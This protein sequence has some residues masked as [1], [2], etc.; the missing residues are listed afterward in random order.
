METLLQDVRYAI[1]TLVKVPGFTVVI[2]ISIALGIAANATVFSVANGL[3]WGVLP[4]KDPGRMVVFS[5]GKSISYPDY[6]DYRDQTTDVFEGG[7]TA[8]FPL[9][10]ASLGG[11]GEPERVW[12]Q[13]VSGNYFSVLRV[14]MA[15]GRPML[16]EEDR[17]IG[18]D[19]VVVLSH[20]LWQR[21]GA[22]WAALHRGGGCAGRV[23]RR[24]PRH[25]LRLLGTA[26]LGG[27]GHV[28]PGD[29]RR[30]DQ[31]GQSVADAQC[32]AQAGS[33]SCPR[34]GG[35]ERRQETH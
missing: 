28:R 6:M 23:P 10:P 19:Q 24:R 32:A 31:A 21:R 9:I 4:V 35:R 18:R 15:L 17:V 14:N 12:G 30:E 7:V 2:I 1:R 20:N 26:R 29:G 25:R 27:T 11:T 5:E 22:E 8:H 34:G 3:L 33:Q 13:A 16:P